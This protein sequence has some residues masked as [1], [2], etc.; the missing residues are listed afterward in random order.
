MSKVSIIIPVYQT[1]A[2]VEEC[3]RSYLA[4]SHKELE[5]LLIDDGSPDGS[6]RICDALAAEDERV[7]VIHQENGG[8]SR[9]RNRGLEEASGQYIVF[10]DSDD[11]VEPDLLEWL[12][13]RQRESGA[14][15]V[16]HA[17]AREL[18][19]GTEYP[20]AALP[21]TLMTPD[22]YIAGSLGEASG[23][24]LS[25]CLALYPAGPA[26]ALRFREDLPYGEDSLY[27]CTLLSRLS[28]VYYEPEPLYHYRV[29]RE[30]NTLAAA[31]LAKQ[32]KVIEA[33]LAMAAVWEE[34]QGSA[35][36]YLLR[37]ADDNEIEAAR[38]AHAEGNKEAFLRHR[39]A[40]R[41]LAARVRHFPDI[42]PKARLRRCLS[43]ASPVLGVGLYNRLRG[44][45]S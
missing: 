41:A 6:G 26:K 28:S 24:I 15:I 31:S 4:Q 7:R 13:D 21:K 43:A 34:T 40:A 5:L 37:L 18:P 36:H 19:G 2:F 45:G 35:W 27:L 9:A 33:S 38:R 1:E 42:S 32:E 20:S 17:Y 3:A 16:C 14:D 10:G 23:M 12:L 29:V 22:E 39:K 30:G 44:F 8:V 25:A 11:W